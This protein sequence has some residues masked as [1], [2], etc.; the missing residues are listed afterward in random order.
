VNF[1]KLSLQR[2]SMS[3]IPGSSRLSFELWT[4]TCTLQEARLDGHIR[5]EARRWLNAMAVTVSATA[6]TSK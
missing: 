2:S 4:W 6:P 1:L 5:P 3:Y